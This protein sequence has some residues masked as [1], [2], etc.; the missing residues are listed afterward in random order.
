MT[1]SEERD[2]RDASLR[3]ERDRSDTAVDTHFEGVEGRTDEVL[4]VSRATAD[5]AKRAARDEAD[6]STP[7]THV[8]AA[9]RARDDLE[10]V[11][12][13][14]DADSATRAERLERRRFMEA[15]LAVERGQTD[16]GLVE[17]RARSDTQVD[18]RDALLADVSHD[19][20]NLLGG[21]QLT[22]D[23]FT[24]TAPDGEAGVPI[25]KFTGAISRYVV[26]MDRLVN[27]L[28]DLSSIEAGQLAMVISDVQVGRL[29]EETVQAFLPVAALKQIDLGAEWPAEALLARLD[30]ERALQVLAN[31]VSNA[32]KFTPERGQVRLSVARAGGEICF[33]VQDSGV[34]IPGDQLARV[35]HRYGQVNR[36][37][38]GLGLGL[39]ISRCIV[40]AHGGRMWAESVLGA[41][42]TFY[43]AVPG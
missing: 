11:H 41:G 29:L 33:S 20:R 10:V 40:E 28:L 2:S 31:L 19:L 6:R 14:R 24:K 23:V 25:R 32:I 5:T 9:S 22:A 15:F 30:D 3:V 4:R 38:R 8:S 43:F 12:Q 42:S 18:W 16:G 39:H 1:D 7:R 34:G 26:R 17:E 13:R 27:D 37:R 21:I 36:D 35:F